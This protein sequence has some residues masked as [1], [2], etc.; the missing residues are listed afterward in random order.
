MPSGQK[1]TPPT[2][3][4]G[5]AWNFGET[6]LEPFGIK[7][8]M[9]F[10]ITILVFSQ[11]VIKKLIFQKRWKIAFWRHFL[12]F[13]TNIWKTNHDIKKPIHT[14][15]H[16]TIGRMFW[17]FGVVM[18]IF[19]G[20]VGFWMKVGGVFP[21]KADNAVYTITYHLYSPTITYTRQTPNPTHNIIISRTHSV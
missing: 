14:F 8:C 16:H 19:V 4:F 2:S 17:K 20:G 9:G 10:V 11:W 21:S 6:L 18:L 3:F 15:M 7:V 13:M 12:G 5:L 1:P